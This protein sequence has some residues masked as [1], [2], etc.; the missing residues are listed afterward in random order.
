MLHKL[1][2]DNQ[3]RMSRD[4]QTRRVKNNLQSS[5]AS[6]PNAFRSTASGTTTAT[7][8]TT[9]SE[10]AQTNKREWEKISTLLAQL[11]PP[12]I[13]PKKEFMKSNNLYYK[14]NNHLYAEFMRR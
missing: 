8:P 13:I 1:L 14:S 6:V 11:D 10:Q 12:D 5:L 9:D 4:L 3:E 2:Y 7:S